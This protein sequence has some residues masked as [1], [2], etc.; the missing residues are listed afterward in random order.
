MFAPDPDPARLAAENAPEVLTARLAEQKVQDEFD[1]ADSEWTA[2]LG[3]VASLQLQLQSDPGERSIGGDWRPGR[4]AK[5]AAKK[6]PAAEL[7]LAELEDERDAAA[8]RLNTAKL[9]HRRAQDLSRLRHGLGVQFITQH[10]GAA[11]LTK[12]P[13]I[14]G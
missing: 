2:K 1:A 3:E 10:P 11:R 7:Q 5:D 9:L 6:L 8:L 14:T 12:L 4:A 13:L